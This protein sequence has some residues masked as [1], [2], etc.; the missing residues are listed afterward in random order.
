MAAL[1][2]S[3]ITVGVTVTDCGES[4]TPGTT[5]RL[6]LLSYTDIDRTA[7]TVAMNVIT[8]LLLKTGKLG[9]EVDSLPDADVGTTTL[10]AGTY[11]S[12]FAH[13]VVAR[14][15]IKNEEVKKFVNQFTAARVVAIVENNEKGTDGSVKWEVY[16][17]DSGLRLTDLES[18][19]AMAD[20][21]VYGLTLATP[22][23]GREGSIPKSFFKTDE[24]TTDA[25]IDSLITPTP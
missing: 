3:T 9:Y 24:T 4:A 6:I 22:D 1:D 10:V 12:S 21:V 7:S 17:W 11:K 23:T 18:T 13:S 14:I 2:C 20:G 5:G 8:D 19:T 16:G 15:F 25:A